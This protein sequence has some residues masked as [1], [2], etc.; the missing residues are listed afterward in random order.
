MIGRTPAT[1]SAIRPLRH[2]VIADFEVT[3]QM[4]RY[5]IRK[6][7]EQPLRPPARRDVRALR[8]HRG[9]EARGRGGVPVG[10][11]APGAADRGAASRPPSAP[12]CRSPSRAATWS[13]TSA[14][15]PARS[16]V[17][18][19][20]GIVVSESVRVGG[21]DL[22][23]AITAYV[24]REHRLA[25]GQQT[26]EDVKLEIGSAWPLH[27]ELDDRDPRARPRLR[28][29]RRASRSRARRCARRSR[30]RCRRS[31]T[32]SSETLER[33]PPELAADISERGHP[34]RRRRVAAAG[35]RRAPA[36][37][38]RDADATWPSRR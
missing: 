29:A 23:E 35:L 17:I 2:G 8:R 38:D 16:R 6:A 5:F 28:P 30:S 36:R 22:D 31:S 4:L 11:R 33:T 1:I 26:A 13:S 19:L 37:R 27:E 10:R 34:A 24:R 14:A 18:S 25:I 12:G 32:R 20:G 3:E 9:R 7:H 21:Y 15:A